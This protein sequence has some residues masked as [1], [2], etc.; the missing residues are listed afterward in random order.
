MPNRYPS[1]C[2]RN[3][4][5]WNSCFRQG[6][7]KLHAAIKLIEGCLFWMVSVKLTVCDFDTKPC[8][9][10]SPRPMAIIE[11]TFLCLK[12][13]EVISSAVL[14]FRY[15]SLLKKIASYRV[16]ELEEAG[17]EKYCHVKSLF[18]IK[19]TPGPKYNWQRR[20]H[21]FLDFNFAQI[22]SYAYLAAA[23]FVI[24]QTVSHLQDRHSS[25]DSRIIGGVTLGTA[26]FGLVTRYLFFDVK[27]MCQDYREVYSVSDFSVEKTTITSAT[28]KKPSRRHQFSFAIAHSSQLLVF[29]VVA[30]FYLQQ[31]KVVPSHFSLVGSIGFL[32]GALALSGLHGYLSA[33]TETH[34]WRLKQFFVEHSQAAL[35][36]CPASEIESKG[37][38][39][40]NQVPF[41]NKKPDY[42][43]YYQKLE[44]TNLAQVSLGIVNLLFGSLFIG[45]AGAS[46]LNLAEAN[47]SLVYIAFVS[48]V[49]VFILSQAP[50]FF[51][52]GWQN[53]TTLQIKY[54]LVKEINLLQK[55]ISTTPTPSPTEK[56][57]SDRPDLTTSLLPQP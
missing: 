8:L 29:L 52:R 38:D 18:Y 45:H 24:L 50:Q 54:D 26:I 6:G 14:H 4:L 21:C 57:L 5:A 11:L 41:N 55:E 1:F 16:S 7:R 43:K 27:A 34:T 35:T 15:Q 44:A 13:L 30:D 37:C 23:I 31:S 17:E 42:L 10:S 49:A 53:K 19:V 12:M 40:E 33:Y 39:I 20:V 32:F 3:F 36:A 9:V 25:I 22:F 28:A 56:G 51:G 2:Q 48:S 47:K 46:I